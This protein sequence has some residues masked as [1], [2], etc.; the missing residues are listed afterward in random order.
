MIQIG[1]AGWGNLVGGV[2]IGCYRTETG[3]F[4][5]GV[6]GPAYF[7]DDDPQEPGRYRRRAYLAE[8]ARVTAGCLAHLG[9]TPAEPVAVAPDYV[10]ESVRARLTAQGQHWQVARRAGP[11]A[12][13]VA[14]AGQAHLAELG[15]AVSWELLTDRSKG[16][17]CWW[18]QIQWLK[19]GD[20]DARA[21][22]PA[23]A[24]CCK[25]GWRAYR[26]WAEH[27]YAEARL[28]AGRAAHDRRATP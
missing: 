28:L 18:R 19:N 7:Q 4:A 12:E 11:L 10:L 2:V 13:L 27:P 23:R 26:T 3:A 9:A 24:R 6:V 15:C 22:D 1:S 14:R 8:A 16:G 20:V 5:A 17:L 25:T 21:A